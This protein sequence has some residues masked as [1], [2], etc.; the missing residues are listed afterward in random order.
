MKS[1]LGKQERLKSRK[2]IAALFEDGA[3]VKVFPLKMTFLITAQ[4]SEFPVRAAFSVPK[5]N[6]KKATDRNR[7]KRLMKEAYRKDKNILYESLTSTLILM[8]TY[9]GTTEPTYEFIEG[10]MNALLTQC[11]TT[12]KETHDDE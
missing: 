2:Q 8:I 4:Q 6:F 11:S 9:L 3:S 1:T 5:R 10:K 7:I 12:L